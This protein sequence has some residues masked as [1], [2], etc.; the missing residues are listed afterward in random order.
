MNSK[1]LYRWYTIPSQRYFSERKVDRIDERLRSIDL[2]LQ[3]LVEA[4]QNQ[5]LLQVP[6]SQARQM[7]ENLRSGNT[8]SPSTHTSSTPKPP[9]VSVVSS[10]AEFEGDTSLMAH[11]L[12]AKALVEMEMSSRTALGT[13]SRMMEALS[14]L[15]WTLKSQTDAS[16]FHN[17]RF[18]HLN[19]DPAESILKP[20]MPPLDI[21]LEVLSCIKSKFSTEF[22]VTC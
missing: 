19:H 18:S 12:E 5:T 2:S 6:S 16:E 20:E 1:P 17:L 14:G 9:N 3:K 8:G 15:Q 13:S 10:S 21:V 4:S 7:H 22:A 11:S